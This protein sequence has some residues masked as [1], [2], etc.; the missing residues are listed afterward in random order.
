MAGKTHYFEEVLLNHIFRTTGY[1]Q[2]STLYVGLFSATPSDDGGGT[3]LTIGAN[4]YARASVGSLDADWTATVGSGTT[5]AQVAN[6]A[7][8]TFNSPTGS[9]WAQV[10]WFGIFDASTAG[11]LLYWAALTTPKTCAVGDTVSFAI[12]ALVVKED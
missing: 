5:P 7:A 9:N 11:N 4:N 1:S 3:E 6:A 8:I 12:G 10:S 2:P